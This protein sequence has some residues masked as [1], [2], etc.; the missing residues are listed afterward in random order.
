MITEK[1]LKVVLVACAITFGDRSGIHS[2][3]STSESHFCSCMQLCSG[4]RYQL[5]P[6]SEMPS[7]VTKLLKAWMEESRKQELRREEERQC[8]E[9][10]RAEEKKRYE[11][12][13]RRDVMSEK[14]PKKDYGTR[15]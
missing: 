5:E 9:Q 8:Y 12:P 13:K 15:N 4:K 7:E 6:M 1:L 14:G 3:Q 10:E 11:Q 2:L